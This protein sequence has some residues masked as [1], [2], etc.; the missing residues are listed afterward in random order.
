M[1][2]AGHYWPLLFQPLFTILE[3]IPSTSQ[4]AKALRLVTLK[5]MLHTLFYAIENMPATG[6]RIIE[7]D[8]IRKM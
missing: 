2:W 3:W 5:Q 8:D 1:W 4:K 6:V 7:I